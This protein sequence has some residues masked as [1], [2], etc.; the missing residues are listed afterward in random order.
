MVSA[1]G[2]HDMERTGLRKRRNHPDPIIRL[3][4][5]RTRFTSSRRRVSERWAVT[6]LAGPDAFQRIGGAQEEPGFAAYGLIVTFPGTVC[7]M[8]AR[9]VGSMC[10]GSAN[11]TP[12]VEVAI[13]RLRPNRM[14]YFEQRG[15]GFICIAFNET[16]AWCCDTATG[17]WHERAQNDM[18]W[19]ARASV[20]SERLGMSARIPED[21]RADG[22]CADFG[23]PM[24]RRYVSRTLDAEIVS[25][26][27]R[28][29][30]FRVSRGYSR[31]RGRNRGQGHTG[32]VADGGFTYGP[33]G[34]GR[35]RDWGL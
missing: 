14:F 8:S 32:N 4:A 11:F 27:R 10:L 31:R 18:P 22:R 17:E 6:G 23:D 19:Q 21:C 26:W 15:H 28:S 13:E 33:Q 34:S 35:R 25:P 2:S 24:V 29:K 9:M 5:F 3:I 1:G 7:L 12:P 30:H 16:F 20:G